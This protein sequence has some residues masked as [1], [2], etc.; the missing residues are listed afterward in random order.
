MSFVKTG[1][2]GRV[3]VFILRTHRVWRVW[4]KEVWIR[5]LEGLGEVEVRETLAY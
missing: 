3:N 1:E 4:M 5:Y 2:V